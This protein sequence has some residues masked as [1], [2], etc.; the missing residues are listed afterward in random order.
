MYRTL[1]LP[2]LAAVASILLVACDAADFC[3][4][5]PDLCPPTGGAGGAGADGPGGG[6]QPPEGGAGG[7]PTTGGGG[8]GGTGGGGVCEPTDGAVIPADCG[9][10]VKKDA[11][12]AGTQDDPIGDVQAAIDLANQPDGKGRVYICGTD[13]FDGSI[14]IPAD[15]S[16]FGDIDCDG[17]VYGPGTGRPTIKGDPNEPAAVIDQPGDN[18]LQSLRIEAPSADVSSGSSIALIVA[19]AEVDI[20]DCDIVAGDAMPGTTGNSAPSENNAPVVDGGDGNPA[21]ACTNS[22]DNPGASAVMITCANGSGMSK[23]GKGGLSAPDAGDAGSAG[24]TGDLGQPGQGQPSTGAWNCTVGGTNGGANVGEAGDAGEP[25]LGGT[26]PGILASS[27]YEGTSGLTGG[28]GTAGQG[29]GGGGAAKGTTD[30][31][32]AT[33]GMQLR[34]GASAGAGGTGG[35]GGLGGEGG[36]S[37]GSSFGLVSLGATVS[38]LRTSVR[39]GNAGDGGDGG[40]AQPGA[41]PGQGGDG[42]LGS[43]GLLPGCDGGNGGIGGNGGGGGGGHGGYSAAIV[44]TGNAP[45]EGSQVVK[46][47]GGLGPGGTGRGNGA[48]G[49]NDGSPGLS[50]LL[51]N[52]DTQEC[53][54]ED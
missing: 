52:F 43:G 41:N 14:S 24:T 49:G 44:F 48:V 8:E 9:V 18:R 19:Q 5:N 46:N 33:P 17:W 15:L 21:L 27:G 20:R 28:L 35:C 10:F 39:S 4:E 12:G 30:C 23:G 32:L 25:G 34:T 7:N 38:L 31:D 53:T 6:G 50:C 42:G 47:K 45:T 29:G 3:V 36:T 16:I 22:A 40:F 51:L 1:L 13:T 26:A 54:E 37:G 11:T 2:T